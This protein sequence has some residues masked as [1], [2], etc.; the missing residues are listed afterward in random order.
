MDRER[1]E[2]GHDD[3]EEAGAVRSAEQPNRHRR[4]ILRGAVL[5]APAVTVLRGNRAWALSGCGGQIEWI[6]LN[7]SG[8]RYRVR[9]YQD[10]P[11]E[12]MVG[13]TPNNRNV[14]RI[15]V[16]EGNQSSCLASYGLPN[17]Y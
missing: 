12:M 10:T 14:T 11:S 16:D 13:S 15:D 5:A 2:T 9:W 8:T 7:N 1:R 4:L 3:R 17:N 6:K